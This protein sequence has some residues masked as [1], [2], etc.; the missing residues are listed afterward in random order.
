MNGNI[1]VSVVMPTYN[2]SKFIKRAVESILAQTYTNFE[3]II[4]DDG[5][6]DNTAQIIHS[7]NDKRIKY[8]FQENKGPASAY[9]TGFRNAQQTLFL[10]WIMMII[11][12]LR[13]FEKQLEYHNI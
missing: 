5:S 10:L 3:F 13:G 6:T 7:Y 11:H 8:I 9:N 4:V 2:G 12:T 1:K